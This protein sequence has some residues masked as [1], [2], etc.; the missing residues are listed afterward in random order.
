MAVVFVCASTG[1]PSNGLKRNYKN[2]VS[3]NLTGFG[4]F[5]HFV[6]PKQG[7]ALLFKMITCFNRLFLQEYGFAP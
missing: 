6:N 4:C 7:N 3:N 2:N 1:T 5:L